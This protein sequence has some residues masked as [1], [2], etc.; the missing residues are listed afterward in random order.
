MYMLNTCYSIRLFG[1]SARID[2]LFYKIAKI[3]CI[4]FI[5]LAFEKY[6]RL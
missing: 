1:K 3:V 4:Y 2:N 5:I 6:V